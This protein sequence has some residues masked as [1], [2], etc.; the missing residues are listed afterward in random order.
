MRSS[1]KFAGYHHWTITGDIYCIMNGLIARFCFTLSPPTPIILCTFKHYIALNSMKSMRVLRCGT[2]CPCNLFILVMSA[3][4]SD[5]A[6]HS[7]IAISMSWTSCPIIITMTTKCC[8]GQL[9]KYNNIDRENWAHQYILD[10]LSNV[11]RTSQIK[12]RLHYGPTVI[13]TIPHFS[14]HLWSRTVGNVWANI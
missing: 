2:T 8:E 6:L 11:C 7:S 1:W 12:Y 4:S 14:N 9:Y 3:S 13:S 10:G 5:W